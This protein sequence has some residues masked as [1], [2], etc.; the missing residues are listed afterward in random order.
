MLLSP[1][2]RAAAPLLCLSLMTLQPLM[3]PA[4]HAA[5]AAAPAAVP[6]PVAG[7]RVLLGPITREQVEAAV[8]EWVQAEVEAKPDLDA[9]RALAQVEPGAEVTILLGTWCGDSRREISRL[10]RALDGVGASAQGGP[11]GGLPFTIRYIGVDEAK[12]MPEAE[13]RAAGLLYVPTLI[14]SRGGHEVGRIVERSPKGVEADL[15]ALL[16]GRASGL[17]TASP[18]MQ[19]QGAAPPR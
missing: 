18:K 11:A 12:K 1:S 4:V 7:P 8:P 17:L 3:T 5:P 14:V 19:Q 6:V 15:L 9:A 2:R 10:W 16:T 13:V